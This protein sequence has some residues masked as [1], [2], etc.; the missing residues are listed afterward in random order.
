MRRIRS[1][2]IELRN[3]TRGPTVQQTEAEL[4]SIVAK[5]Q[6]WLKCPREQARAGARPGGRCRF[7]REGPGIDRS[8][9][10]RSWHVVRAWAGALLLWLG[11]CA[12]P[13]SALDPA[14]SGAE[15]LA[16]LFWAMLI[17]A[18][19]IWFLV[20]GL[21][22][23]A[24]RLKDDPHHP[25]MGNALIV[26]GGVIF[27][28]IVLAGLLTY[29]LILMPALRAP[30]DGLTIEVV[31]KQWWWEVIYRPPGGGPVV[32]ANEVRLPVGRRVELVLSS[33]D[34]IHAFWI[35]AL[36]GKLDAIPGVVNES[37]FRATAPGIYRGQ[38]AEFCGIQHAA[39]LASVEALPREEFESWLEEEA[40]AQEAGTSDLGRETYLGACAK[41]HGL[42]GEGDIGPALAGNGLLG[43]PEAIEE[44]V[45]NGRN[46][47]PPVGKDWEERQ[48][49][50]LT[51]FLEGGGLDGE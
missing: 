51:G 32:S 23:Y 4:R 10:Q 25:V 48:M 19:V 17:G 15:R 11:G 2:S 30:G 29:G 5:R 7:Q 33:P 49:S 41:C 12:G 16:D 3:S 9:G 1:I 34:V 8:A 27:P 42:A 38:C 37:W 44:V 39:M 13:Q 47:M 28:T 6:P 22:V 45:R 18:A 46:A 20:I 50:A 40:Q 35:P 36:G 14:G 24:V 21:A 43:D 31:G 26:G